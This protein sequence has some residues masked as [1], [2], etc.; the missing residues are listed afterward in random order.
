[1]RVTY[2]GKLD[3]LIPAQQKK[4]DA[5]LSK[6]ASLVDG[7]QEREAHVILDSERHRHRAEI[8]VHLHDHPLVGVASS[9]DMLTAMTSAADKLEKQVRKLRTRRRDTRRGP[10]MSLRTKPVEESAAD[11]IRDT[12][13]ETAKEK[14]VFRANRR[15]DQK[16]LTLEEALL[17]IE[18]GRDYLVYRDSESNRISVLLRRRDG[19]FDLVE[20]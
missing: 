18:D 6:L 17:A 13:P 20:G 16:P 5:K 7:K 11:A 2:K 19:N 14:K 12:A 8:T 10:E 9:A 15:A 4:W 1:M 3:A